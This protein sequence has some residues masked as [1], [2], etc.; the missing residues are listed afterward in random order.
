MFSG[1]ILHFRPRN[2][3]RFTLKFELPLP[4]D[5]AGVVAAGRP[6]T[7]KWQI[8]S[9]QKARQNGSTCGELNP[10]VKMQLINVKTLI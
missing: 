7:D 3:A 10:T 5:V 6:V 2:A 4:S 1:D 8:C 9:L